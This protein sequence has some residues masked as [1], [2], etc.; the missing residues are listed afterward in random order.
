[1]KKNANKKITSME[2]LEMLSEALDIA[3]KRNAKPKGEFKM[4]KN[5]ILM[6]KIDSGLDSM[7]EN[8]ISA[9][10]RHKNFKNYAEYRNYFYNE[11]KYDRTKLHNEVFSFIFGRKIEL[12]A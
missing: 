11:L 1:M 9:F 7:T 8:A 4:K 3:V 12:P 5:D 2:V 10:C 6:I